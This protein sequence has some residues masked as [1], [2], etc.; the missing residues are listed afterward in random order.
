MVNPTGW[1]TDSIPV[2]EYRSLAER[3][4]RVVL[5]NTWYNVA[6]ETIWRDV[7][8]DTYSRSA[9]DPIPLD[10]GWPPRSVVVLDADTLEMVDSIEVPETVD[11]LHPEV[12]G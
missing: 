10:D 9:P 8:G 11:D 12:F 5:V 6:T 4:P 1:W 3:H 7:N 2:P